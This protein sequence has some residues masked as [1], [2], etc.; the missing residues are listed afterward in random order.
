MYAFVSVYI[1]A[2]VTIVSLLIPILKFLTYIYK[3]NK[4]NWSHPI[5]QTKITAT[6]Y[7]YLPCLSW[8][9]DWVCLVQTSKTAVSSWAQWPCQVQKQHFTGLLLTLCLFLNSLYFISSHSVPDFFCLFLCPCSY[10]LCL[11][12]FFTSTTG[13]FPEL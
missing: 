7:D 8:K 1:E 3:Y 4:I 6:P 12:H 2:E 9:L 11:V 10:Q 5:H 13:V